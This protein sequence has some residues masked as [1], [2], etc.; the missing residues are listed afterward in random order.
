[1]KS[2]SKEKILTYPENVEMKGLLERGDANIIAGDTGYHVVHVREVFCGR[3]RMN[4]TI[5]KSLIK[6]LSKR[7]GQ[8]A[9]LESIIQKCKRDK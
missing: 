9:K 6:L 1:M 8:R 3:R 5:Q 2:K 4:D 7:A